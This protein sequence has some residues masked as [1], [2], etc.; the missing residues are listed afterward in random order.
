MLAGMDVTERFS[1]RVAAYRQGRIGYPPEFVEHLRSQIG[2]SSAWTVVDAGAGTGLSAEPLLDAGCRVLAVE[3]NDAM[4]AA[5]EASLGGRERFVSVAGRAEAT[6]LPDGCADLVLA[7]CAFHWFDP[8]AVAAEWRRVLRGERWAALMWTLRDPAASAFTAAFEGLI[9][10]WA[11]D[12]A[13]VKARYAEPGAMGVVFGAGWRTAEFASEQTVDWG[14]L[15]ARVRS[16]SYVPAPGAPG[17]DGMMAELEALY[18]AHAVEGAVTIAYRVPLYVG[19]VV[20]A[21]R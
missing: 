12:Y 17:H 15:A 10:R 18:R 21:G 4:R 8:A 1:D 2:L 16:T 11:T 19:R 14:G 13:A 9:E 3:P 6:T 20:E 5:A 7:A